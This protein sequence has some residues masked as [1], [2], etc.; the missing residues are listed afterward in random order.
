MRLIK[1]GDTS[2]P[3]IWR[4]VDS[5]DHITGK[6]GLSPTVVISKNGGSFIAVSGTVS[7]IGYGWYKLL[8]SATD[9]DTLGSL[10][11]YAQ[12]TGADPASQEYQVIAFDPYDADSLG[13]TNIPSY[14]TGSVVADSGNNAYS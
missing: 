14:I 11:L 1:R 6:T 2:K 3:L 8:P 5:S 12:A 13:L 7:E 9:V 4:M 10:L